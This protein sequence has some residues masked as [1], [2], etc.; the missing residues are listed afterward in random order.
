MFEGECGVI[1]LGCGLCGGTIE[2]A[3]MALVGA[4]GVGLMTHYVIASIV[5]KFSRQKSEKKVLQTEEK[6]HE[7]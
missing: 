5:H 2:T 3:T 1:M 4:G 7:R 6:N